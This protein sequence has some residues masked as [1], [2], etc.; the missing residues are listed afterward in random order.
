MEWVKVFREQGM[1]QKERKERGNAGS[2]FLAI[3]G[4]AGNRERLDGVGTDGIG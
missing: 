2:V 1:R 4:V 3:H